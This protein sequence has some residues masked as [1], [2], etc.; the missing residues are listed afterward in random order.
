MKKYIVFIVAIILSALSIECVNAKEFVNKN[1][2]YISN[3]QYNSLKNFLDDKTIE[4]LTESD[5]EILKDKSWNVTDTQSIYVKQVTNY[6]NNIPRISEQELL[7]EE[8]YNNVEETNISTYG[9]SGKSVWETTY[10]KIDIM[11][12]TSSGTSYNVMLMD[13]EWKKMP[14]VRSFDVM[15]MLGKNFTFNSGTGY[16]NISYKIGVSNYESTITSSNTNVYKNTGA[17][18]SFVVKLPTDSD[19]SA[20][21]LSMTAVGTVTNTSNSK[22]YGTYQHSQKN[23]TQTQAMSHTYSTSGLGGVLTYSD[24]AITNSYDNMQGVVATVA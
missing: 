3:E 7:T 6:I 4:N 19:L 23:I 9:N 8:Q 1:G 21:N 17:G 18:I 16:V 14:S 24:S 5:F 20:Y 12:Y 10:K 2:I 13:L 15:A 22:V 11:L